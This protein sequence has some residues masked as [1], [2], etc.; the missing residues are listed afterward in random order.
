M[1]TVLSLA[2][3]VMDVVVATTVVSG[4]SFYYFSAVAIT[5]LFLAAT[6]ADVT[7]VADANF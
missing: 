3:M 4:L 1:A 5:D 2:A 6:D 7:S